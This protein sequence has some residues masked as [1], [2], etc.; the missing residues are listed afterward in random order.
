MLIN[1]NG[2]TGNN[3]PDIVWTW[4]DMSEQYKVCSDVYSVNVHTFVFCMENVQTFFIHYFGHCWRCMAVMMVVLVIL[5]QYWSCCSVIT[6][7]RVMRICSET[8]RY[9]LYESL[10]HIMYVDYY[11]ATTKTENALVPP[12][13]Y[14]K[15][16]TSSRTLV[17]CFARN[18]QMAGLGYPMCVYS[19]MV[20]SGCGVLKTSKT[21]QSLTM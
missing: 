6:S 3:I 19:S 11:E 21:K 12:V 1:S 14:F 13:W 15:I 8:R 2:R 17:P 9:V 10:G 18:S 20:K 4:S 7:C 16:G 5:L